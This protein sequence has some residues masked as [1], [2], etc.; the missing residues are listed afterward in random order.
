MWRTRPG[1]RTAQWFA[2]VD[3]LSEGG[4]KRPSGPAMAKALTSY[5][6]VFRLAVVPVPL[7]PL[8]QLGLRVM[9]LAAR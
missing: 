4:T 2:T 8:V 3:E 7:R 6:D 1:L 9:A 5:G